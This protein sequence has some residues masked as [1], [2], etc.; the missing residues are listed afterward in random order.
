[1]QSI[2]QLFRDYPYIFPIVFVGLSWISAH[3]FGSWQQLAATYGYR[4][5][6][7]GQTW[8]F[9]YVAVNRSE[10]KNSVTVGINS[11]GLYLAPFSLFR[12]GH[13]P[14]LIPWAELQLEEERTWTATMYA[15]RLSSRPQIKI[16][17]TEEL[18]KKLET[19][20]GGQLP[21]GYPLEMR[22]RQT[23]EAKTPSSSIAKPQFKIQGKLVAK[24]FAV[25][26]A[27]GLF[28]GGINH[29]VAHYQAW[30]H[31]DRYKIYFPGQ[32]TAPDPR[33]NW[34]QGEQFEFLGLSAPVYVLVDQGQSG[35]LTEKYYSIFGSVTEVR[36]RDR[37]WIG[38]GSSSLLSAPL[39]TFN[40]ILP[41][42]GGWISMMLGL[43][44]FGN[45]KRPDANSKAAKQLT[46]VSVIIGHSI[47]AGFISFFIFW[48][49]WMI[50]MVLRAT[51]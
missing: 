22:Q 11:T 40:C 28:F 9:Q 26:F 20:A 33:E 10:Y 39:Y 37:E 14:I 29:G 5:K 41:L 45:R 8:K 16:K 12:T 15:L 31:P 51:V 46:L 50:G 36:Y 35:S 25:T 6:F 49:S 32:Y 44:V 13:P 4:E 48:I 24:I 30:Q 43:A 18:F 1:M 7:V 2:H 34:P 42:A 3:F 38:T 47:I 19:A 17:I 21:L 27:I 23:H